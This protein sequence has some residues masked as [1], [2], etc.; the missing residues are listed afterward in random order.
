MSVAQ[1]PLQARPVPVIQ[2]IADRVRDLQ[3]EARA[4]ARDHLVAFE[5][6]LEGAVAL[7]REIL[8][9]GEAYPVGAREIARRLGTE[10]DYARLSLEALRKR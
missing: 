8:S 10:L 4:L 2:A 9:G 3:A 6:A 1:L 5:Q 7:A